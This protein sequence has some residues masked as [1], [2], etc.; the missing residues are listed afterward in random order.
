MKNIILTFLF[1]YLIGLSSGS[2]S[3]ISYDKLNYQQIGP[4][5]DYAGMPF[6]P[7]NSNTPE[8]VF[9]GFGFEDGIIYTVR[10]MSGTTFTVQN[11]ANGF[12]EIPVNIPE[13]PLPGNAFWM[14]VYDANGVYDGASIWLQVVDYGN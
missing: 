12:L 7:Y 8:Y 3:I 11:G 10:L 2:G 9:T 4:S 14:D 13:I 6:L 1:F 5:L